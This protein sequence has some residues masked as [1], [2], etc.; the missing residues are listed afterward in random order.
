MSGPETASKIAAARKPRFRPKIGLVLGSGL[1]S[2]ADRIE[3]AT[4]IPYAE[5]PNFPV[6]GVTGHAGRLI[7]G[8][9]GGTAVACLQGRAHLFEGIDPSVLQMPVRTLKCLGCETLI[10]TNA[11]GSLRADVAP[12]QLLLINDHINMLGMSPL[13]GPNNASFGP[14]FPAMDDAYDAKLRA[15][16]KETAAKLGIALPEGVYLASLGPSFETPAEIRAYRALGA[17]AVGFS[18]VPEVLVARHCGLKV[19]AVSVITNFGAGMTEEPPDHLTTLV[20][21]NR[22]ATDLSRLL[23]AVL[24]TLGA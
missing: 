1:G 24:A 13:V 12:G 14:R 11:A 4:V 20:Q 8:T 17:D 19:A 23:A 21:A 18:T 16:F 3:D 5:L 6:A 15:A 10:V 9:L 2:V 22:A 7:L